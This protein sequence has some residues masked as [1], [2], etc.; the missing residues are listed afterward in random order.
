M[1]SRRFSESR[2]A[3]I[4]KI[5]KYSKN[6]NFWKAIEKFAL[7]SRKALPEVNID[8]LNRLTSPNDTI[9]VPGKVLAGGGT[10]RHPIQVAAFSFS[11]AAIKAIIQ[12]GGKV[13]SIEKLQEQNPNGSKVKIIV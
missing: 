10:L 1:P 2:I 4:A 8:K 7:K 3:L 13:I 12:G 6:S 9:F 5:R 11:K